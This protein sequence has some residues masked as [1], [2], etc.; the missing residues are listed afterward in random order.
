MWQSQ[1]LRQQCICQHWIR[2]VRKFSS[3][4]W[5][6]GFQND[7]FYRNYEAITMGFRLGL[8]FVW[9]VC[10]REYVTEK[11]WANHPL[12]L[13]TRLLDRCSSQWGENYPLIPNPFYANEET[14]V[15][16]QF[17]LVIFL[18]VSRIMLQSCI[19]SCFL[20]HNFILT[21]CGSLFRTMT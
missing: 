11:E 19:I 2:N 7:D 1:A 14:M 3:P 6:L 8:A 15:S 20:S 17:P 12:L 10:K 21:I 18:T 16:L 4:F 13:L 9:R 5:K